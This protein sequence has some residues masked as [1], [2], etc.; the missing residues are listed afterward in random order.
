MIS[1]LALDKDGNGVPGKFPNKIFVK[2]LD[3]GIQVEAQIVV[4]HS[5]SQ[6]SNKDGLMRVPVWLLCL[7]EDTEFTFVFHIDGNMIETQQ[8]SGIAVYTDDT[9]A[10]GSL[11]AFIEM[12]GDDG[13]SKYYWIGDDLDDFV[14]N[15]YNIN[16]K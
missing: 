2:T 9:D 12:D 11:P 4:D 13:D 8:F 1:I 15:I 7:E 6:A 5:I 3:S 14:F 16:C 10:Y